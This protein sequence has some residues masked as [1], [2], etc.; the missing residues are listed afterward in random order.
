MDKLNN[1]RS[2]KKSV[3]TASFYLVLLIAIIIAPFFTG[4]YLLYIF[5]LSAIYAIVAQGLNILLGFSG[6]ISIG[7]AGFISIGAYVSG[8]LALNF[9]QSL[10]FIWL[11]V[12]LATA[13]VGYLLGAICL[14]MKGPF[15]AL[16]T[17][18]FG[19][20]VQVIA[21][22]LRG[23]TGGPEGLLGVPAL[24]IGPFAFET[25][26]GQYYLTFAVLIISV[27]IATNIKKSRLGR[28]FLALKDDDI[29]AQLAGVNV[30]FYKVMAFVISATLAGIA[31][32]LFTNLTRIVFPELFTLEMSATSIMILVIGGIGDIAGVILA[33]FIVEGSF[34]LLRGLREYQVI[35]FSVVVIVCIM[36]LPQGVMGVIKGWVR[37]LMR[38][39]KMRFQTLNS[40]AYEQALKE[41]R[42][43]R[44]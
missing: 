3:L 9:T 15:L 30:K 37:S 17:I 8:L 12:I 28:A 16:A 14:K 38:I 13:L 18:G 24:K 43:K 22:N 19:I 42:E 33:A 7:H 11:I 4:E 26:T 31:G 39:P 25:S 1:N 44:S 41:Y 10:V 34:E 6:Q 5:T 40:K 35:L 23:I 20:I 21:T 29:S 32:S 27:L 36:Y 2:N